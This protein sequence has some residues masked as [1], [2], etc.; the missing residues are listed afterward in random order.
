MRKKYS[1]FSAWLQS[2]AHTPWFCVCWG[3]VN[4]VN[5]GWDPLKMQKW[6]FQAFLISSTLP[7]LCFL[8]LKCRVAMLPH[9]SVLSSVPTL[10]THA[11]L[12]TIKITIL[13]SKQKTNYMLFIK[14]Q[15]FKNVN[16]KGWGKKAGKTV[17]LSQEIDFRRR[18]VTGDKKMDITEVITWVRKYL[19]GKEN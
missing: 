5:S 8:V 13:D 18:I 11:Q 4:S 19:K 6:G 12:R 7:V 17:S 3:S 10:H 1:V 16:I 2:S 15:S 9:F 14:G